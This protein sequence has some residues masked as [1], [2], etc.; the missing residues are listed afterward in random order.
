MRS[1]MPLLLLLLAATLHGQTLVPPSQLRFGAPGEPSQ[2]RLFAV[3][4]SGLVQVHLGP[5]LRI[6]LVNGVPTLTA[7]PVPMVRRRVRLTRDSNGNYPGRPDAEIFRNGLLQAEGIDYTTNPGGILPIQPWSAEDAVTALFFEAVPSTAASG[8][9]TVARA[10]QV[11]NWHQVSV[12][13]LTAERRTGT[14]MAL[15]QLREGRWLLSPTTQPEPRCRWLM[16]SGAAATVE[17]R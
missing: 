7:A 3:G 12:R 5:G 16:R 6:E 17:C 14:L 15:D 13:G 1:N 11:K 2:L 4:L 9:A 10:A 8:P